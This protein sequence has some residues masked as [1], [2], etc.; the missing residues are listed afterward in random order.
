MD[1]VTFELVQF[2]LREPRSPPTH[3]RLHT[4][5]HTDGTSLHTH[6]HTHTHLPFTHVDRWMDKRSGTFSG[7]HTQLWMLYGDSYR[8]AEQDLFM[9]H[10]THTHTHLRHCR[11]RTW[12]CVVDFF[13]LVYTH[14]VNG[15]VLFHH[16]AAALIF[17]R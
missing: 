4:H 5:T 2:A 10:T 8:S 3:T 16:A 12:F 7:T 15:F 9:R 14:M 1:A 17:C 6:T 13:H 11:N